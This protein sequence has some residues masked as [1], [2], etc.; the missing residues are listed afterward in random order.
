M[1]EDRNSP[2][3]DHLKASVTEAIGKLT[4]ESRVEAE[5]RRKKRGV[6]AAEPDGAAPGRS[7]PT[8]PDQR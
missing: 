4:G 5:G 2:S 8:G 6:R 3:A 7:K 1:T